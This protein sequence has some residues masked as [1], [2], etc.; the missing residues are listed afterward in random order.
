MMVSRPKLIDA[1]IVLVACVVLVLFR[2]HA[3]S[4]P[5]ETDEANYAYI[6]DRL[7]HGD[8]LYIDVW[9]HQP[10][11]VFML[12]AGAI[13]IFGD[14]PLVIRWL[15]TAF[16][17][18][19]LVL[20]FAILR[21]ISGRPAALL[22]AIIFAVVSS[23]PGTGG[24]G[25][26]REIYMNTFILAAWWLALR[27]WADVCEIAPLIPK[28]K[29]A[30][31][32]FYGPCSPGEQLLFT[33]LAGLALGVGSVFKINMAVYWVSLAAWVVVKAWTFNP[34]ARF[35]SAT[36]AFAAFAAGPFLIWSSTLGYF[37][38]TNRFNELIEAVFLVN[39]D[40]AGSAESFF[41]RFWAFF[42]PPRFE[43][44]FDS[45][46]PL[47]LGAAA[48]LAWLLTTALVRPI[49]PIV[50]IAALVLAAYVAI[51]LPGR[52]WPHY[53]YLL[54][55]PAV[56]AVSLFMVAL[57]HA[58]AELL[59]RR[60]R[61]AAISVI[62]SGLI[63]AVL[64]ASE[65]KHYLSKDGLDITLPRYNT[66]DFWGKAQG[67]NV[68]RVTAPEDSIFVYGNDAAIYY[69]SKRK[70]ASRYTMITGLHGAMRGAEK[71]QQTLLNELRINPPRL[72]IDIER[73][74]DG[75]A[76]F[77][78]ENYVPVG[79]DFH[80]LKPDAPIMVA[81]ARKDAPIET[82]DWNWDRSQV[83]PKEEPA[84]KD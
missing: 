50:Q 34:A 31:H 53:Y 3:F 5:L 72:I 18:A 47:W 77:L 82:I 69:Y 16:S 80:D 10:P 36:I 42:D 56:I 52:F 60:K 25:A 78:T 81:F 20:I 71:R 41:T 45:A 48:A 44:I 1:A 17:V 55:P 29:S 75:W 63:V 59:I 27:G 30:P 21:R 6:G 51:C 14:S 11:G 54:I 66:R 28:D 38:L 46:F 61:T 70:C 39:L 13:Q 19:T 74:F 4:L 7:L 43:H 76:E 49:A 40:Y 23:D 33:F 26:N 22:G 15:A 67:E 9:D 58:S 8:K 62:A 65:Y 37:A 2:L 73:K 79:A 64:L 68:A 12:F 84:K 32:F 57:L 35:K 24:E 83:A